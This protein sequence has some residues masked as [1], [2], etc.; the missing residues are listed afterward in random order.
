VVS[1]HDGD[2]DVPYH[3]ITCTIAHKKHALEYQNIRYCKIATDSKRVSIQRR[4]S[5]KSES[6]LIAL[7]S[8]VLDTPSGRG[9]PPFLFQLVAE[10]QTPCMLI[11]KGWVLGVPED[12][13]C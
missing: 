10:T 11:G 7:K 4:T 5:A 12:Q 8:R 6:D 13:R 2:L 1:H 3:V 9:S